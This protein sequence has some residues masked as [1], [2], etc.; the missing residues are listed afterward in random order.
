[1]KHQPKPA[2]RTSATSNRDLLLAAAIIPLGLTAAARAA[3]TDTYSAPSG[4]WSDPA[5]W[6]LGR[7]PNNTDS[8]F[9]TN[10]PA[11]S[12]GNVTVA[13]DPAASTGTG[14]ASV[15]IQGTNGGSVT[16]D[17]PANTFN[18]TGYE[19]VARDPGTI[20]SL[21]LSGGNHNPANLYLGYSPGST[22]TVTIS[23]PA[24]LNAGNGYGLQFVGYSGTGRINQI[25]GANAGSALYLASR[26]AS[27]GTY[28][29]AG[30]SCDFS[31]QYIA[32]DGTGTFTQTGGQNS[33]FDLYLG[34][35]EGVNNDG[36]TGSYTLSAGTLTVSNGEGIGSSTNNVTATF[37]QTGGTHTVTGYLNVGSGSNGSA[38][39]SL[40][41]GTL[42]VQR[43]PSI[44]LGGESIGTGDAPGTFKQTGGANSAYKLA[45]GDYAR[46]SG[47]YEFSDGSLTVS[48]GEDLGFSSTGIFNQSGG[49]HSVNGSLLVGIRAFGAFNLSGDG[50]LTVTTAPFGDSSI[51]SSGPG[52]FTQSGGTFKTNGSLTLGTDSSGSGTNI[53]SGGTFI[54]GSAERI[55]LSG[56]GALVQTGGT[57]Y[58]NGTGTNGLYLALNPGST[59]TATLSGGLLS[60]AASEYVGLRGTGSFTQSAGTHTIGSSLVVSANAG[61]STGTFN[62]QGGN[63]SAASLTVNQGGSLTQTGGALTVTGRATNHASLSVLAGN[64]SLGPLSG[65]GALIVGSPSATSI[66]SATLTSFSQSSLTIDSTGTLTVKPNTPR[67]TNTAAALVINP[68]GTLDLTRNDL[69]VDRTLTPPSTLRSYLSSGYSNNTWTGTGITS[70]LAQGTNASSFSLGW[71]DGGDSPGVDG[72]ATNQILVRYTHRGDANLDG[73]VDIQDL[74]RFRANAGTT[75]QAQWWQAD[76]TYDGKVDIQDLLAF[77]ANAG[78]PPVP[79]DVQFSDLLADTFNYVTAVPEPGATSLLA[80]SGALALLARRKRRYHPES[81]HE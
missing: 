11:G 46:G 4:N 55:A 32:S 33:A 25:A 30:G 68:G 70:S 63:L 57:H 26:V 81:C 2:G 59:G 62:L 24:S 66:A 40:S 64:A 1:M 76:F 47:T 79:S 17:H 8:V 15:T 60:V 54:V 5:N 13:F 71:A 23:A 27:S 52:L 45:L 80:L 21:N 42:T 58:V 75:N 50:S 16:L 6:S 20:G 34:Y 41:G 38:C 44:A 35:D 29:L 31:Y 49:T 73:K 61:S 7:V 14:L 43:Y 39:F 78:A 77:R 9:V 3:T 65:T 22:G 28:N 18:V 12:F 37:D 72:L 53:L 69:L 67:A 19:Y 36:A 51:G 10:G 56:Q 74:L 48:A